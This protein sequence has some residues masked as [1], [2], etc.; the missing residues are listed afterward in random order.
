[1]FRMLIVA[2]L[3]ILSSRVSLAGLATGSTPA[4]TDPPPCACPCS[5]YTPIPFY[6]V[7]DSTRYDRIYTTSADEVASTTSAG[8]VQQPNVGRVL[9]APAS[10]TIPL[11]R[12]RNDALSDHLYTIS[13]AERDSLI[14]GG[15]VY[16]G[17]AA[18]GLPGPACGTL[19]LYRLY[20]A[21]YSAHFYTTDPAQLVDSV[22]K[23]GFVFESVAG[24]IWPSD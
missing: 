7:V 14:G 4:W 5:D 17:I 6:Y 15:W 10:G 3:C 23:F 1:M 2:A 19:P 24:Y 20:N 13:T 12:L 22:T 18:Y 9:G 11:Y 8:Y 16:E 21:V